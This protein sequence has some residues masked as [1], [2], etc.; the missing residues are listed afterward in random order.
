MEAAG[1]VIGV[2]GLAGLFSVCIES[3]DI[4]V[5]I[6]HFS[7]DFDL[8]CAQVRPPFSL[9]PFEEKLSLKYGHSWPCN[10]YAFFSGERVLV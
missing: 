8:L 5:N 6:Q 10:E 7:E 2:V 3:L 4:V 9:Y 1:L